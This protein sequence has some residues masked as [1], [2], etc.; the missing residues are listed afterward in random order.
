M[1]SD[2]LLPLVGA[3]VAWILWRQFLPFLR[4]WRMR[5]KQVPLPEPRAGTELG[6]QLV[7]FWSPHC[8]MCVGMSRV[9]DRLMETRSDL[10]KV[11]AME[12]ATLARR[13]G[14]CATPTLVL[15]VDGKVEKVLLGPQ[16][17]KRILALLDG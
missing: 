5:G 1:S 8:G 2:F 10:Q 9:V 16:S 3:A 14:V 7:Y 17:E 15:V 11:N 13:Y 6:R 12:N 4:A